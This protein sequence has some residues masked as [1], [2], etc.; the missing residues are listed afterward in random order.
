MI[1]NSPEPS[2]ILQNGLQWSYSPK[3][4][5]ERYFS[6]WVALYLPSHKQPVEEQRVRE[7]G[8][9]AVYVWDLELWLWGRERLKL[10]RTCGIHVIKGFVHSEIP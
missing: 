8:D 4:K 5:T 7:G 9:V 6:L 10:K 2:I 1:R 3:P